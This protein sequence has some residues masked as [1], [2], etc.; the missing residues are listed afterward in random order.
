M[1]SPDGCSARERTEPPQPLSTP[2]SVGEATS[3]KSRHAILPL[4]SAA[5]HRLP[6]VVQNCWKLTV[7]QLGKGLHYLTIS[8]HYKRGDA[9]L[10]H[11]QAEYGPLLDRVIQPHAAGVCTHQDAQATP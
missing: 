5:Q 8:L 10:E 9:C 1:K 2:A 4:A 11:G 7:T 3:C 6:E